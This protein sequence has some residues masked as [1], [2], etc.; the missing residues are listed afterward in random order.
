MSPAQFGISVTTLDGQPL[1]GLNDDKL[2]TP[3][4][5]AKLTTTAAAYAL[6]PV[7]RSPGPRSLW[8]M[9]SW[10]QAV[11]CMAICCCWASA[12]PR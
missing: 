5:N 6:L 9:E 7:E 1:Y 12:I 2:F 11:H 8:A 4:S 3:A 10:T